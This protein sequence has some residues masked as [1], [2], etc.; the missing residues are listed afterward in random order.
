MA[1]ANGSLGARTGEA[2]GAPLFVIRLSHDGDDNYPT[3]GTADYQAFVR[4][5]LPGK[6]AVEIVDVISGD[7]GN[8]KAEYDKAND[9]LKVR[10][11]STGA[12]AGS[13]ADLS[14]TTFNVTVLA[15]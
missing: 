11:V 12:E 8:H 5:L 1:L 10:L 7:C 9:K 14:S 4:D 2:P 13:G 15:K 6:A 3:G